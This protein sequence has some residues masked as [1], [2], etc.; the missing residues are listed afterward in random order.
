MLHQKKIIYRNYQH[1]NENDFLYEL[2]QELL[3]VE[4]YLSE[5]RYGSFTKL[6]TKVIDKHAP[7]KQKFIRGNNAPFITKELRKYI[8]TRSRLKKKYTDLPSRK[9]FLD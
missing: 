5:D 2:D 7:L 6:F 8:M 4:F 3:R 9:F 1:F